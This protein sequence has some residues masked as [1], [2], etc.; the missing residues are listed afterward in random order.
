MTPYTTYHDIQGI[1]Y[2]D[3]MDINRLMRTD[4]LYKFSDGTLNHVRTALN[5]IATGIQMRRP[6]AATKNHMIPSY[7]VLITQNI[8]SDELGIHNDD[9]YPAGIEPTFKQ[10][11]GRSSRI[12]KVYPTNTWANDKAILSPRFLDKVFYAGATINSFQSK[13]VMSMSVQKSQ[14]HKMAKFQDGEE[15]M[16]G[17]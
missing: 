2:Q 14:V 1:I 16:I 17:R 13:K 5:D 10:A 11:H 8:P 12:M 3:D 7:D 15:I 6:S 4:E 9:G